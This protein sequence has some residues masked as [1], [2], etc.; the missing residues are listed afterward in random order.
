MCS[1]WYVLQKTYS[2][3][4]L[5]QTRCLERRLIQVG[6]LDWCVTDIQ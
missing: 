6:D 1:C 5:S 2:W 4:S 3:M